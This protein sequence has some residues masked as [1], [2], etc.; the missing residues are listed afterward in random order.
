MIHLGGK[1]IDDLAIVPFELGDSRLQSNPN[2]AN[3]VYR[4]R[5]VLFHYVLPIECIAINGTPIPKLE[6]TYGNFSKAV[7]LFLDGEGNRRRLSYYEVQV[8]S[9]IPEEFRDVVL[10]HELVELYATRKGLQ[11]PKSHYLAEK[12]TDKYID[13]HLTPRQ[14]KRFLETLKKLDSKPIKI[15]LH[16][17]RSDRS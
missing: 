4:W 13:K 12:A 1:S 2:S 6:R 17:E 11:Y 8:W 10:Y 9:R 16:L 7:H 3:E 5:R 14:K 15:K